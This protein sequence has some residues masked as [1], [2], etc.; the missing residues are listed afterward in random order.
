LTVLVCHCACPDADTAR[1]IAESVVEERLAACASVL[2]GMHSVYRWRGQVERAD[3]VLLVL[4]TSRG[5]LSALT[6]RVLALHPYELPE[7]VAVEAAGGSPAWLD[8]VVAETAQEPA[9]E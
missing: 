4:K 6:E 3:E 5:R 2:P 8:W 1:S 7:L 9:S